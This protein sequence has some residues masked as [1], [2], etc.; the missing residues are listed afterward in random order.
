MRT[1][2]AHERTHLA[3]W[4]R[5]TSP[6]RPS[7]SCLPAARVG[8]DFAPVAVMGLRSTPR[9]STGW[10]QQHVSRHAPNQHVSRNCVL[11]TRACGALTVPVLHWARCANARTAASHTIQ[12]HELALASGCA[13][14]HVDRDLDAGATLFLCEWQNRREIANVDY[15]PVQPSHFPLA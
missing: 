15:H 9:R 8:T 12:Q 5:P 3:T 14:C 6:C 13:Q 11:S 1:R 4:P 10:N 7:W 2:Q